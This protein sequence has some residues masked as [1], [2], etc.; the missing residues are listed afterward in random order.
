[1]AVGSKTA[2]HM[3]DLILGEET[4]VLETKLDVYHEALDE[5]IEAH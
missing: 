4:Y 1:M 3:V 2:N 5:Y